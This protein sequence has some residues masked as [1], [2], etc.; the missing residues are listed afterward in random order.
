MA[1]QTAKE[2]LTVK[3]RRENMEKR[4][5]ISTMTE[6]S[7]SAPASTSAAGASMDGK[8]TQIL[9]NP[10]PIPLQI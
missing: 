9:Y 7:A 3:R 4:L 8:L 6:G 2:D 1:A 10:F 5:N